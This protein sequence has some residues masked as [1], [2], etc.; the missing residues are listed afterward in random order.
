MEIGSYRRPKTMDEAYALIVGQG[1]F[2]VAGGAWSHMTVKRAELAVDL[3]DLGL[4]YIR[5][6]GK[7]IE[8]G[9]MTAARDLETSELLAAEYGTLFNDAMRHIV[10]VQLRNLVTAGGTIAGKYGFSDLVTVLLALNASLGFYGGESVSV[11][12]FLAAPRGKPF[13]LEKITAGKGAR[14]A[15]QS[16]RLTKNDFAVLNVCAAYAE[17]AWRV[18]VGA[19]PAAARQSR[20]AAE[21]LG[22]EGHPSEA[23]AGR[24]GE[25]A[26][27]ELSFGEDVRGSAAYRRAICPVLVKRAI[28]EASR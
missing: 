8:I 22:R 21:A 26:A 4:N 6:A 12:D 1:G 18:A 24:A 7:A 10:G 19:R 14:A 27:E 3:S 28:M 20:A 15:F 13:F 5:D 2:P 16:L 11:A 17:G 25:A 23:T 9:A